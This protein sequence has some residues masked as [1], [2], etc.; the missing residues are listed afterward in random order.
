MNWK[1]LGPNAPET[2]KI[3]ASEQPFIPM[4]TPT[5][6]AVKAAEHVA[7]LGVETAASMAATIDR[8]AVQPAV[9]ELQDRVKE[10]DRALRGLYDNACAAAE[11][12]GGGGLVI[13]CSR[14][15]WDNHV[16]A[17]EAARATLA[18][19]GGAAH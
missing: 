17:T 19:H 8:L 4:R 7:F 12:E 5:P 10:L 13:R 6:G 14:K 1:L 11:D 16:K 18:K 3:L 15:E 9:A 2:Q